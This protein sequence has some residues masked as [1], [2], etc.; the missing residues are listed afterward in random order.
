MCGCVLGNLGLKKK[1]VMMD[2][3]RQ[4]SSVSSP[5]FQASTT[6]GESTGKVMDVFVK[7][8]KLGTKSLP[9]EVQCVYQI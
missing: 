4:I 9:V 2:S 3:K 8:L 6:L 1:V 5:K 7:S